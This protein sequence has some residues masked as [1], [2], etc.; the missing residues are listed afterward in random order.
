MRFDLHQQ[1]LKD[2]LKR[3]NEIG[4]ALDEIYGTCTGR[5]IIGAPLMLEFLQRISGGTGRFAD[6]F[7]A[8]RIKGPLTPGEGEGGDVVEGVIEGQISTPSR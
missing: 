2:R 6:V 3:L 7:G 1:A 8:L 4:A 5:I